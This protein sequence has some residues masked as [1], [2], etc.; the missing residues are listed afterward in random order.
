MGLHKQNVSWPAIAMTFGTVDVIASAILYL[1]HTEYY[2]SCVSSVSMAVSAI[3]C[4]LSLVSL[5]LIPPSEGM[6]LVGHFALCSEILLLV[7]TVVPLPLYACIGIGTAYSIAF[8]VLNAHFYGPGTN[9]SPNASHSS[10]V[11]V[12][13]ASYDVDSGTAITIRILMQLSIHIIGLH[14]LIMTLVRMR[15]TFMKV[16]QSLLV[17]K[18]LEMEKQLKEKMIHSVM[19]P[20]VC[21]GCSLSLRAKSNYMKRVTGCRLADGRKREGKG[22]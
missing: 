20:K 16:G 1:T 6:T 14:I 7:Y 17:R 3:L 11:D 12:N 13:S 5:A 18:Q 8:E 21:S 4:A 15:G 9:S 19:P 10:P 22:T 2:R